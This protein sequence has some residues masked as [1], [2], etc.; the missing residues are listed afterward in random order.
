[1]H[2]LGRAES[3][4]LTR[5]RILTGFSLCV[6]GRKVTLLGFLLEFLCSVPGIYL[7][8]AQED[9]TSLSL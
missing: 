1:M 3:T 5:S 8:D 6:N 9:A 7:G 2:E 4:L